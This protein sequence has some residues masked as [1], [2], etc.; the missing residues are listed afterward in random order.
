MSVVL[1]LQASDKSDDTSAKDLSPEEAVCTE[2]SLALS[3]VFIHTVAECKSVL[4]FSGPSVDVAINHRSVDTRDNA[5]CVLR[6]DCSDCSLW[7]I[8]SA[9]DC[10][11]AEEI[12][13]NAIANCLRSAIDIRVKMSEQSVEVLRIEDKCAVSC[14]DAVVSSDL[15]ELSECS[16]RAECHIS[17]D[18]DVGSV[19]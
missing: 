19:D 18:R 13:N 8:R 1:P 5:E 6:D 11:E 15:A 17:R 4:T 16:L 12:W 14:V 7:Q 3:E 2:Q 10:L 9:D